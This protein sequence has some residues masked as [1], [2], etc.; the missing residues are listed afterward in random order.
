[1][2]FM[3]INC[4]AYRSY[5]MVS[6]MKIV[7]ITKLMEFQNTVFSPER[8]M[9]ALEKKLCFNIF[10]IFEY[11]GTFYYHMVAGVVIFH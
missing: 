2:L 11:R 5:K 7:S 6:A 4:V 9:I 8:K 3:L 1:M 10:N